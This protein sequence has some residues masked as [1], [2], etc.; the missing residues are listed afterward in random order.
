M[1]KKGR[2]QILEKEK[3]KRKDKKMDLEDKEWSTQ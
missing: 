2:K 1:M 3:K